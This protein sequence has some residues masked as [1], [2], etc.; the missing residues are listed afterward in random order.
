[1]QNIRS[2]VITLLAITVPFIA[3]NIVSNLPKAEPAI[4]T[5]MKS[6]RTIL[7]GQC[8]SKDSLALKF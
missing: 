2:L 8:D 3:L 5:I 7:L 4:P 6:A 1:M